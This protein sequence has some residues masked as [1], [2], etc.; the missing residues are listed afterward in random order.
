MA[1]FKH[2]KVFNIES[3]SNAP[4][5]AVCVNSAAMYNIV[6]KEIVQD[7]LFKEPFSFVLDDS[8]EIKVMQTFNIETS[9]KLIC[10]RHF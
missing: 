9:G 4:L 10:F 1:S 8:I 3:S 5:G 6:W 7:Q 2:I